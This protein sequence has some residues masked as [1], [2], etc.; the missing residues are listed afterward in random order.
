[1]V[2]VV[3]EVDGILLKHLVTLIE[4]VHEPDAPPT[5]EDPVTTTGFLQTEFSLTVLNPDDPA[6][7]IPQKGARIR[8]HYSAT[9][10]N[11]QEFDNSDLRNKLLRTEFIIGG[12]RILK[13]WEKALTIMRYG[14]KVKVVCPSEI[15]WGKGGVE[16]VVPPDMVVCFEMEILELNQE[17]EV[18]K[19]RN[20]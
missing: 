3:C 15:A 11:G 14:E 4:V 17:G 5:I 16:G 18:F 12:S 9:F 10:P 6:G 13:C 8:L 1:M 20:R 19:K 7:Q 2:V